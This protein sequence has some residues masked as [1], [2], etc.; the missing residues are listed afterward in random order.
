MKK[1]TNLKILK[2]PG[3]ISELEKKI[4]AILFSAEEPLDIENIQEKLK[5][6][7]FGNCTR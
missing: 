1:K 5:T 3:S 2:F 7:S 6:I 4:E